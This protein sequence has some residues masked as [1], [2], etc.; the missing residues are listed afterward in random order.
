VVL[1]GRYEQ[2]AGLDALMA[3]AAGYL[4]RATP[5]EALP[6]VVRGLMRGETATPRMLTLALVE[7]LRALAATMLGS[8]PV[9]SPLTAREWEVLDLL[10][11]GASSRD[12]SAELVVSLETVHSDVK[13]ILHKLGVHSRAEAVARAH[14]LRGERPDSAGTG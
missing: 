8:R 6:R 1:A 10:S 12:I 14:E 4:R 7:R 13:H 2:S 5:P 3:G 9:R 11:A